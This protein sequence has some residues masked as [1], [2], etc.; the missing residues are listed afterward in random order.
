[1][2]YDEKNR[3]NLSPGCDV[4]EQLLSAT[5][6][7]IGSVQFFRRFVFIYVVGVQII[8]YVQLNKKHSD[9]ATN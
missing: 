1:M 8:E 6:C 4:S 7:V 5:C 2:C 9:L 3:F